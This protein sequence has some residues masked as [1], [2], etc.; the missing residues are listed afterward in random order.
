VTEILLA[1]LVIAL[2]PLLLA[3]LGATGAGA[4]WAVFH[5]LRAVVLV[6]LVVGLP[7]GLMTTFDSPALQ[8]AALFAGFWAAGKVWAT[9]DPSI[10]GENE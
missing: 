6:L 3:V 4:I 2:L 5:G 8:L 7:V 9:I 10:E 1:L